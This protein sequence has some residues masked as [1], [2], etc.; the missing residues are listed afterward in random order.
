MNQTCMYNLE[1]IN[2]QQIVTIVGLYIKVIGKMSLNVKDVANFT[3]IHEN[4]VKD[5]LHAANRLKGT[6]MN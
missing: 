5:I 2:G 3:L 4:K 1:T 6:P